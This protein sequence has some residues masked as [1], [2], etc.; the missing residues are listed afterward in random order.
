MKAFLEACT[1]GAERSFA[2][3]VQADGKIVVGGHAP[4]LGGTVRRLLSNGTHDITFGG[5]GV[6]LLPGGFGG[7]SSVN[8]SGAIHVVATK[9]LRLNVNP[10]VVNFSFTFE[11]FPQKLVVQFNDDVGDS[12]AS[13]DIIVRNR[14]TNSTLGV[15]NYVI[16]SFSRSTNTAAISFNNVLANGDYEV[17]FSST[18]IT[19]RQNMPL[20]GNRI[21]NFFFLL[22]DANRDRA[23]NLADFN[24]LAANFGQAGRTFSQGNFDYDPAGNVNLADFNILAS[25]FGSALAGV[26][27]TPPLGGGSGRAGDLSNDRLEDE[28]N[29][30]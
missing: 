5:D 11:T 24:I 6:Y 19:N 4:L 29:R 9:L 20:S 26:S 14:T 28:C 17:T 7:V 30:L 22:G 3:D 23:V 10:S 21:Q 16:E 18:G 8:A 25:R 2:I 27:S 15:S 1:A 12:L 13:T